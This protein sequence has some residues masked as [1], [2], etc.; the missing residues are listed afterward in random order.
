M[1][2]FLTDECKFESQS[3]HK[4]FLKIWHVPF[5]DFSQVF[6]VF[7]QVFLAQPFGR[8]FPLCKADQSHY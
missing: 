1:S 2:L 3:L 5:F 7:L 6:C 8:K 4:E